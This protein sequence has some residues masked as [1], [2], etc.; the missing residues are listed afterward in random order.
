M[1]NK[2]ESLSLRKFNEETYKVDKADGKKYT[3]RQ[4]RHRY[5]FPDEWLNFIS[6]LKKDKHEI[7]FTTLINTGARIMEVLHIKPLNFDWDR[8]VI[9]FKVVKQRKAKKQFRA[10]GKSRRFFVSPQYIKKVRAYIR[11]N[12]IDD[13][14]YLFLDKSKLPPNYDNLDNKE[15][16]KYYYKTKCSISQLFKRK[17]KKV[18]IEDWWN[19]SL[20]NIRKTYGNWMRIY[21]ID[22]NELCYRMGHDQKTFFDHYGSSLLFTEIEKIKIRKILGDQRE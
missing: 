17:L 20:H 16:R 8:K 13:N 2:K 3:V 11:K 9:E 5:F 6:S 14:D 7:L 22:V 12:N 15:K 21:N 1:E 4:D 19:F 10:L 18:G